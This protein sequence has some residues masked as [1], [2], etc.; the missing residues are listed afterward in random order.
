MKR[1]KNM[2]QRQK[3]SMLSVK[4]ISDKYDFHVNTVRSWVNRDGL[5]AVKH[6]PGGKLFIRQDDV[7]AFIGTWYNIDDEDQS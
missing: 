2:I 3:V 4:Q 7:E 1:K 6:G 5:R